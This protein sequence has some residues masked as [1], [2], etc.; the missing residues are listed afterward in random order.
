M[1]TAMDRTNPEGTAT[2]GS[3]ALPSII[4]EAG[5]CAVAEY[6]AFLDDRRLRPGT[7]IVYGRALCRFFVWAERKHLTLASIT[8]NTARA[9]VDTFAAAMALHTPVT[10]LTPVRGLFRHLAE[11]GVI[12]SNPLASLSIRGAGAR[13]LPEPSV[14]LATLKQAVLEIGEPDGW[15]EESEEM[16]AGLVMLAEFSIGTRDP[17]AISRFTGVPL[18]RVWRICDRLIA[19]GIWLPDGSIGAE[20]NDPENGGLAFMMDVWV[21]L[22]QL[23]RAKLVEA[24][25]GELEGETKEG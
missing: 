2:V 1:V 22:G 9:Y 11:R 10:Y 15:R 6:L 24:K 20:W 16:Q 25:S 12:P 17:A 23:A 5:E 18:R 13:D 3:I 14:S 4:L 21:A 19:N 8:A 7:R